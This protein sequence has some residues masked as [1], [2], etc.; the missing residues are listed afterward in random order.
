MNTEE[1]RLGVSH[2]EDIQFPGAGP[3]DD[4]SCGCVGQCEEEVVPSP[5]LKTA[6]DPENDARHGFLV[7]G[8]QQGDKR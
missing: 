5:S 4:Q 7:Q 3:N 1:L 6:H 2:A 8:L